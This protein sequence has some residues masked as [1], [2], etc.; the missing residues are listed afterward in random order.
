MNYSWYFDDESKRTKQLP[1]TAKDVYPFIHV[2]RCTTHVI[3]CTHPMTTN[4]TALNRQR[5]IRLS[6]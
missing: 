5:T 2:I 4:S 3:R 6:A 1:S